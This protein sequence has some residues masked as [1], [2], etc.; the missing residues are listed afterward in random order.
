MLH[1][2]RT[3]S[4]E[5]TGGYWVCRLRLAFA[6][7]VLGLVFAGAA[8]GQV[9]PA[10]DAGRLNVSAGGTASGFYVQYGARKMVGVTG[11]VDIDARKPWGVEAEGRWLEWN[12]KANVHVETYSIGPRYHHNFGKFQPYGKGMIGFG[13]FNFPYNYATGRYLVA[14]GGGGLDYQISPRIHIRAVDVE[15]QFWPE[16]TFGAMTTVGV[17][18][19]IR[20]RVF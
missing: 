3:G 8:Q 13:D 17:S 20:V 4:G 14:T 5:R 15:Y 9:V 12:Q 16:F 6:G 19:G 1:G 18:T 10:G 11:F 2:L 7:V